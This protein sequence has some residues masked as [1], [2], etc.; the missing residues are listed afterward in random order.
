MIIVLQSLTRF[1][2]APFTQGSL[3]EVCTSRQFPLQ[4]G[5]NEVCASRQ[6][7]LQ[8]GPNEVC[9]S[10]QFPLQE[11]F[12]VFILRDSFLYTKNH[13]VCELYQTLPLQ[14]EPFKVCKNFIKSSPQK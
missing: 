14:G 12:F 3:N 10:R 4:E 5:P 11:A 2:G 7:P 8:E 9:A 6:F 1:A 13:F